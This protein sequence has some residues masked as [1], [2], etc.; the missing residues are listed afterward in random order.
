MRPAGAI[1]KDQIHLIFVYVQ[2]V[3]VVLKVELTQ[4]AESLFSYKSLYFQLKRNVEQ[5]V[6]TFSNLRPISN[7]LQI[8]Q[9]HLPKLTTEKS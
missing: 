3:C 7:C 6:S 1:L 2:Y 8:S 5:G 4:Q 9:D